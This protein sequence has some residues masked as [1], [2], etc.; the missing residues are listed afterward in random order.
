VQLLTF[1]AAS[2][3]GLAALGALLFTWKQVGQASKELR[4]SEHGQ[5]TTRFN[6][7]IENLGSPSL[8]IR[9][10]GIY[11]LGRI[12]QD[13]A[14]DHPTVVSVL[15]AFTQRHAGSSTKSLK[16]PLLANRRLQADVQAAI[17]TLA[18]RRPE[19]DAGTAIDLTDTDLRGLRFTDRTI[20]N[21]PGVQLRGA[22][23]RGAVLTRAD[24]HGSNMYKAN[25]ATARL[26]S[27]NLKHVVLKGASLA[28]TNLDKADLR[29]ADMSCY[30]Y[31]RCADLRSASI[32]HT[33]LR[34]AKL[35]GANLRAVDAI[36]GG[37]DFRGAVLTFSTLSSAWL[38]GA[39]F[40]DATVIGVDFRGANLS[41]ANFRDVDLSHSDLRD[42]TLVNADFRG[43]VL[44]GVNL[45]GANRLGARGL[46]RES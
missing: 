20:F 37:P 17:T 16:E 26:S 19:L 29:Q 41:G 13:S 42:A 22:D 43:A 11:A 1:L 44:S 38:P 2:L 23:L 28:D 15:T 4:I 39:D 36:Y 3:P 14:R 32:S 45:K 21:L 7:A 31:E 6:A 5:I 34:N 24:L 27:A 30:T 33:D 10:G 8:D 18:H 46:P 9:L 12:M 25:L 35:V 40:R